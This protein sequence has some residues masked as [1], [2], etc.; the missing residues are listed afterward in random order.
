MAIT[1]KQRYQKEF[2]PKAGV[3]GTQYTKNKYSKDISGGGFS[4]QPFI[5]RPIP[6]LDD[7]RIGQ[8]Y[9]LTTQALSLDF[10]VRGGS[11]EEIA[12]RED[13]ARIDR[14]FLYYPQGK[15]FTDKYRSLL[16]SNPKIETGREAG[17]SNTRIF[18]IGNSGLGSRNMI[19]QIASVGVGFH[20]PNAGSDIFSLTE[21][22]D[23]YG[24]I[25]AKKPTNENRLV[26][27]YNLKILP[28]PSVNFNPSNAT[29]INTGMSRI[30]DSIEL[31]NYDGGPN[32]LYG[33]TST[34]IRR[35]T[36][37]RGAIINTNDAPKFIRSFVKNIRDEDVQGTTFTEDGINYQ[38]LLA[39]S[40]KAERELPGSFDVRKNAG[41]IVQDEDRSNLQ[42]IPLQQTE[43]AIRVA[44]NSNTDVTLNSTSTYQ[45]LMKMGDLSK[46]GSSGGIGKISNFRENINTTVGREN[47]TNYNNDEINK[48]TRVNIGSP[49]SRTDR[50]N[51]NKADS[52]T[53]D[54]L[55][56][57]DIENSN[58]NG[59]AGNNQDGR[60]FIK[61]GFDI[62]SNDGIPRSVNFRAF[63]TGYTD[64]HSAQWDAQRYAGRGEN[65]YNYQGFDRQVSF[66]FKVAAQ[67]KQEML[68]LYRKLNWLLSTLY[69]DYSDQGFMRGNIV[70]L[71]IGD[72][73][74]RT[75]GILTSLNLSLQDD[76]PWEI[77]YDSPERKLD[78]DMLET[79]QIIDVAASFNP[80]LYSLPEYADFSQAKNNGI[81][82]TGDGG[83]SD[84]VSKYLRRGNSGN[85]QPAI[86]LQNSN[87]VNR[88]FNFNN[89]DASLFG[90]DNNFGL[91]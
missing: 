13:F 58:Y 36:D 56:L 4:G 81:L 87:Q 85:A 34:L 64:N 50:R 24:R 29:V 33:Q 52:K 39:A 90:V 75:P 77:A 91:T 9:D 22:E 21:Q 46:N 62:I 23:L 1:L 63:L 65:F 88:E 60:D 37:F 57:L 32:S 2:N 41:L 28:E 18:P 14:F 55:N 83:T 79:P 51:I 42:G 67:S 27:L 17:D 30:R 84:K 82:L 8:Y 69:P 35:A 7:E 26:S 47:T 86:P 44:R 80:I 45:Q 25:V 72:L 53:Q 6:S 11:Y 12:S 74:H 66:N 15:A 48:I 71:T 61:F 73:F 59:F 31:F 76:Y 54:T 49:G 78:S 43:G 68:P 70:R 10:P 16:R 40:L 89:D 20:L 5:K 3:F 19:E 38:N